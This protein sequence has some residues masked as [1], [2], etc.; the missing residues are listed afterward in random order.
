MARRGLD[1]ERVVQ[2]AARIADADGL[3]ALTLARLAGELGVRPPS[4]YNHFEGRREGL[5]R[6][7]AVRGVREL[8]AALRDAAVGRAGTD[9]LT[10]TAHAHRAYAHAHPGLYAAGVA[11]PATGDTEHRAAA[12]EAVEVVLAVLRGWN[13]EGDEAVHAARAFRSAVH[14]F[15]ALEAAGGFGISVDL[16]ESFE[17][18]VATLADGFATGR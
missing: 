11:A 17:R 7:L 18:L 6:A 8:T 10:A 1:A 4:L 15:V 13:L 14:G 3:R 16:D 2:E 9:A 5:M 12:Q